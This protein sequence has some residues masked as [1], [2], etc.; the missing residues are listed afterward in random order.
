M[1]YGDMQLGILR[2]VS[3]LESLSDQEL[4]IFS[5]IMQVT[6]VRAGERILEEGT[7]VTALYIVCDGVVHVRRLA[8][9]REMLLGRLGVGGF[10][11][12]INLFDPGVATASI[13]AM[14][15]ATLAVIEYGI[16]RE[17]MSNNPAAGY[18]IV[19]AMMTEMARRLR[20]TS[21]RLVNTVYWSSSEALGS[22]RPA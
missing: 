10:F 18:K 4:E 11:G 17:F 15:A 6:Q 21:S 7:E 1:A 8:Q 22:N 12:E 2:T 3:I 13:Y 9:K 14:K 19:S 5:R 16:M 20:Q